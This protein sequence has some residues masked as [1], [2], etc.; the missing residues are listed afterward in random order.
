MR[1]LGTSRRNVRV[2]LPGTG[3]M[4]PLYAIVAPVLNKPLQ[5]DQLAVRLLARATDDM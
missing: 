3:G 4:A 2:V 5:L 1:Y